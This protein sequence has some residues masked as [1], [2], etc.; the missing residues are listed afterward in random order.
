MRRR[1]IIT[2]RTHAQNFDSK[3]ERTKFFKEL[4]GWEQ[5]VP[6]GG[7]RYTYKREGLL[8][9]IPHERIADSVFMTAMEHMKEIEQFFKKWEEKVD[10]DIMDVMLNKRRFKL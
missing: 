1:I 10:F 7:R 5:S 9:H 3:S 2:F 4:H 6:S 8:D